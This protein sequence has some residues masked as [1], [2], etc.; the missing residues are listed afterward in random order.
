MSA[1]GGT[2]VGTP[3]R[4]G[5]QQASSVAATADRAAPAR[6]PRRRAVRV[7]SGTLVALAVTAMGIYAVRADGEPVHDLTLGGAGVW[8][9]GGTTAQ[10]ARAN[11]GAQSFDLVVPGPTASP[12]PPPA[13]GPGQVEL[14]SDVLQDG[15]IAVGVTPDLRL[16]PIDTTTGAAL[17]GHGQAAAPRYSTNKRFVTPTTLDLRG[18]TIAMVES[19]TGK[20]WAKRLSPDGTTSLE[21]FTTE[22]PPL[23]TT[24]KDAALA[25]DVEGNVKVVSGDAGTVLDIPVKGE[26]FGSPERSTITLE[27]AVADITAVGT[28][29]VV[30]DT[31]TG[32]IRVEG[33]D[34]ES[35]AGGGGGGDS[36]NLVVAALQQPGPDAEVVAVQSG[37]EASFADLGDA[38][39]NDDRLVTFTPGDEIEDPRQVAISRPLVLG[40]CLHAAWG[41]PTGVSYGI[42][43][44]DTPSQTTER[45]DRRSRVQPVVFRHNGGEQVL[46][47]LGTG[48]VF[49]LAV[50]GQD[51]RVDTWPAAPSPSSTKAT[52]KK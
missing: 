31:Q 43:C 2:G 23:L 52:R 4:R 14:P 28:R 27:G 17:E 36:E 32:A 29:W 26:G 30:M 45:L 34:E 44:G 9:S 35:T 7:V 42:S 6:R 46:N 16:V 11:R 8:V 38:S 21:D 13:T 24:G 48:H 5:A 12:A 49:D 19:A 51:Y 47:D 37:E 1:T 40:D 15:L 18:G 22:A 39:I 41:S 20:V 3:G 50:R 25:V 10:W 33:S